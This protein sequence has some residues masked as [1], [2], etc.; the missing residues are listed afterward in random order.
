[1]QVEFIRRIVSEVTA[2]G[3]TAEVAYAQGQ[4]LTVTLAD[5]KA[6]IIAEDKTAL[7]RGY[8]LLAKAE[9][10]GKRTLAVTERRHIDSCG[11]FI[12]CS[13]G[14]VMTPA[15]VKR[16]TAALAA[17]GLNLIVLYTEDTYPVPEYPYFG[18]LRGRYTLEEWKDMDDYA[19]ALGVELV[20]CVQ[21]LAHL[22]QFLQWRDN[23]HL[24]DTPTCLL[25]DE[26]ETYRFIEAEIRAIRACV[27]TKRL[28]IGM[29]E[30]HGVGLNRYYTLHGPVDRFALL[31]RHL[32]RVLSIARQ[33]GFEPFMWSD[34]F[35]RLGSKE[36]AY[37]DL[38]SDL[39][40][41]VIDLIPDVGM[42]YWD[43]YH[44]EERWYEH[45]LSQ[46]EKIGKPLFFAG[47]VWTW[48]G[49]LPNFELTRATMVPALKSCVK[50]RIPTV[51]ATMWGDDGNETDYFLALPMMPL[52]SEYCWRG[53]ACEESEREALG[54][55]LTGLPGQAQRAFSLFYPGAEDVRAG[56]SLVY[57]DLLYPLAE[58]LVPLD[59]CMERF[60]EARDLLSGFQDRP[61]CQYADALFDI[62]LEKA[63][64]LR[65]IR[66][67]YLE[68][69]R[70][71]LRRVA[72]IRIPGLLAKYERLVSL[73]RAQWE[74]SYKRNGWEVFALRYGAVMGRLRD[75]GSALLRYVDGSLAT[76]CE[77]DEEP[78]PAARKGGMQWYQVYVSPQ[79]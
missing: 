6:Q 25:I 64:L 28:H 16:Y 60:A 44:A 41:R 36:N 26:P 34:M 12:D 22:G 63:R 19:D 23:E 29:D 4:G 13:R 11:A 47:G 78:L 62:A 52:F 30:A 75:V 69:D 5:G 21:T 33:Y 10:E 57:C 65:E 7:A 14:A 18:Y 24:K 59:A 61:D 32:D 77:L 31:A 71:Y 68:K 46:H 49:F 79:A 72:E 35:F 67:K 56:K 20:P 3:V 73:H 1:M 48:S 38:E 8:F 42:C 39:P 45:M 17:L 74:A 9:A 55:F 70:E 15:A 54:A 76:L 43:Y 50:R 58:G 40:Q 37:Y 27:R 51:M 53:E 2:R 66:P